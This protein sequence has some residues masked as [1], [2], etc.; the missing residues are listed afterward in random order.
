MVMNLKDLDSLLKEVT[1]PLDH[2]HLNL[3]VEYFRE[4][5]PTT[6]NIARFCYEELRRRLA[7]P[8]VRLVKVRLLEGSDLWVDYTAE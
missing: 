2:H 1:A 8:G 7:V 3:D 4:R 5:V 6:E